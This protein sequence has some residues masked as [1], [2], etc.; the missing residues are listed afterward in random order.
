MTFW[1]AQKRAL[2]MVRGSEAT[3]DSDR[4]KPAT[5]AEALNAYE[6]DLEV[7]LCSKMT[8][9]AGCCCARSCADAA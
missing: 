6:T 3:G 2:K 4:T 7:A 5:V 1:Q 9:T 8:M